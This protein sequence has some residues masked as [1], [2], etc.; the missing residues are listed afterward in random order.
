MYKNTNWKQI[1]T[2]S[3]KSELHCSRACLPVWTSSTSQR[4]S[5]FFLPYQKNNAMQKSK[6]TA[7]IITLVLKSIYKYDILNWNNESTLFLY[8]LIHDSR[9]VQFIFSKYYFSRIAT[10]HWSRDIS[11]VLQTVSG[12]PCHQSFEFLDDFLW[13]FYSKWVILW[14]KSLD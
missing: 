1:V 10:P 12:V 4:Q 14:R 6:V 13:N 8:K 11:L 2:V 5:S 7:M 3:Y 9:V